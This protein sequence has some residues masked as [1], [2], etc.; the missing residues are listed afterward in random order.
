[1]AGYDTITFG[2]TTLEIV[3]MRVRKVPS[4]LKQKVGR[5]LVMIPV[6]GRDALDYQFEIE[7]VVTGASL[8]EL[9]SGR[10]A[11]EALNDVQT[12]SLVTGISDHA[13]DYIMV[14]DSLEWDD[15]SDDVQS[16]YRY[17]FTL[18]Q[19]NQ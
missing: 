2:G 5:V 1:M 18:I 8:S 13:G 16:L 6:I 3:N 9:E 14:P 17:R 7:G 19:Y 11:I 10:S 12:H 15:A 4:T